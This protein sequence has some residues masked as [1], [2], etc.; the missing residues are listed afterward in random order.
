MKR[1]DIEGIITF[2]ESSKGGRPM[3]AF[4]GFQPVH[5]I[6][7]ETY[8]SGLHEYI[9]KEKVYPGESAKVYIQFLSPEAYPNCLWLGK[10]IPVHEG[11]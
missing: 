5:L 1:R 3:P 9:D 6:E 10:K 11:S 4:S 8:T 2:V 7:E